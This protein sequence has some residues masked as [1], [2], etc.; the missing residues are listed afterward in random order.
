MSKH[1]NI[2]IQI[3]FILLIALAFNCFSLDNYKNASYLENYFFQSEQSH[4]YFAFSKNQY[5]EI[6]PGSLKIWI[7]NPTKNSF[8]EPVELRFLNNE[9]SVLFGSEKSDVAYSYYAGN[10]PDNWIH[11]G[12]AYK[13]LCMPNVYEGIDLEFYFKDYELEFDFIINSQIDINQII[14]EVRGNNVESYIENNKL[15]IINNEGYIYTFSIPEIYNSAYKNPNTLLSQTASFLGLDKNTYQIHVDNHDKNFEL[16]IDPILTL[17]TY[18]FFPS[19]N[20]PS[21]LFSKMCLDYYNNGVDIAIIG[22]TI[23]FPASS[24]TDVSGFLCKLSPQLGKT[25][26]IV[27]INGVGEDHINSISHFINATNDFIVIGGKT[28]S[29]NFPMVNPIQPFDTSLNGSG[30]SSEFDG[31]LMMFDKDFRITFSTF[32]GGSGYDTIEDLTIYNNNLIFA[33]NTTSTDLTLINSSPNTR[34]ELLTDGFWGVLRFSNP[35]VYRYLT[36]LNING[37][38]VKDIEAYSS[39]I[40]LCGNT[41]VG[42]PYFNPIIPEASV[43]GKDIFVQ[44]YLYSEGTTTPDVSLLSS[45]FFGGS[46]D[47]I[48]EKSIILYT[49]TL[50]LAGNTY[51]NDLPIPISAIPE[52]MPEQTYPFLTLANMTAGRLIGTCYIFGNGTDV[53]TDIKTSNMASNTFFITGYTNSSFENFAWSK[54]SFSSNP[55]DTQLNNGMSENFDAMIWR[56]EWNSIENTITPTWGTFL[57]GILN[58]TALS[59]GVLNNNNI[60]FSGITES[61]D[62]PLQGCQTISPAYLPSHYLS[63]FNISGKVIYVNPNSSST[64]TDGS[65]WARGYH[66]ISEAISSAN[67]YDEIW[68]KTGEYFERI[69]INGLSNIILRGGFSGSE[70]NIDERNPWENPTKI[71]PIQV[72][73]TGTV[74]TP[75]LN[76]TSCM[77]IELNGLIFED[78][79]NILGDGGAINISNSTVHISCSQFYKNKSFGDG[80]AIYIDNSYANLTNCVF[81]HNSCS[82]NGSAISANEST[83]KIIHCTFANNFMTNNG[84]IST[85]DIQGSTSMMMIL[86]SIIWA[87]EG[88]TNVQINYPEIIAPE[89]LIFSHSIIQ[90][91]SLLSLPPSFDSILDTDP[92]FIENPSE[93]SIGNLNLSL[94]SPA[95]NLGDPISQSFEYGAVN[96]DIRRKPRILMG[97]SCKPDAGAFEIFPAP[98][99]KII[100]LGDNPLYLTLNQPYIEPGYE[101]RDGCNVDITS[102][103]DISSN[104]NTEQLGEYTVEYS[105]I[106]PYDQGHVVKVTRRVI[107]ISASPQIILT[108]PSDVVIECGEFF[109]DPGAVAFDSLGNDISNEIIVTDN[110]NYSSPGTYTIEYQV[111][112]TENHPALYAVRNITIQDTKPPILILI[113]PPQITIPCGSTWTDPGYIAFD[114]CSLNNIEVNVTGSVNTLSTGTYVITYTA[115]DE[116][117]LSSTLTRSIIVDCNIPQLQQCQNQCS[118]DTSPTDEDGDGLSFCIENCLGTSDQDTDTDDDGMPDYFEVTYELNPLLND[119]KEDADLDGLSNLEEFLIKSNPINSNSP[120]EAKYVSNFGDDDNPGTLNSPRASISTTLASI[121]TNIPAKQNRQSSI[122]LFPGSYYEDIVLSENI[123]LIG[124]TAHG[125]NNRA[126]IYGNITGANKAKIYNIDIKPNITSPLMNS[127]KAEVANT[128]L[129]NC[130][131]TSMHIRNVRFIGTGSEIGISVEGGNP[132]NTIIERCLFQDLSIGIL[133]ADSIPVIRKCVFKSTLST[134]SNPTG[135]YIEDNS[136]SSNPSNSLGDINDPNSGWNTFNL[137]EGKAI[138]SERTDEITAHNNDW[139]TEDA[140]EISNQVQG[141]LDTQYYL[142]KGK[143][144]IASSLVC[145]VWNANNRDPILNAT[146]TINPSVYPPLTQ[147]T[148]GVYTFPSIPDGTYTVRI[149]A[150]NFETRQVITNVPE[151]DLKSESVALKP[152]TPVEGEGTVEGTPEGSSEGTTEGSTEGTNEGENEGEK[153]VQIPDVR[154]KSIEEATQILISAGLRVSNTIKEEYSKDIP[155]GKIVRTEPAIGTEVSKNTEV[156]LVISKGAKRRFI[157]SCGPNYNQ[158]SYWGDIIIC[159]FVSTLLLHN[160]QRKAHKIIDK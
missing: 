23:E 11:S 21:S 159:F 122:V 111:T 40:Y 67:N 4:H 64:P 71:L 77:N 39:R 48:L 144:M 112:E 62:F 33:G 124:I 142:G 3:L 93:T 69:S 8:C 146:V 55:F 114:Q 141:N 70:S 96:E 38:E 154:G 103:V 100:L 113:G 148:N 44:S 47:D 138:I 139:G 129:L 90:N 102:L 28:N 7:W 97:E 151:G 56:L 10:N 98:P 9:S 125:E 74:G 14:W 1:R 63:A 110:V 60:C 109:I 127:E 58:D 26:H 118:N 43:Q 20:R 85:V 121:N 147:N 42:S 51:S 18:I 19:S 50:C 32:V 94:E 86:N 115:Y 89:Y 140:G 158:N 59:I 105:V 135:I 30:T 2:F 145:V 132:Y 157:I 87:N 17:S 35:L 95:V 27:F 72:K 49:N 104:V 107:V 68:I 25:H 29:L 82:G 75:T 133:I 53:I 152:V 79:N 153:G 143:A 13:K 130:G 149:T 131:N 81:V 83:L 137:N 155:K 5:F 78:G 123:I 116:N 106:S 16:L 54:I 24:G 126:T 31:F 41:T 84:N 117:E 80:G 160:R 61:P 22:G 156:T 73:G 6:K 150:P 120:W 34:K 37:I 88:N 92:L 134:K 119:A 136:G 36:K 108:G 66:T 52:K 76:I 57:G 15:V 12:Y 101:A 45:L 91:F 46:N 65:S 99:P 128:I